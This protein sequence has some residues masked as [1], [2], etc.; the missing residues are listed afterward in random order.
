[1]KKLQMPTNIHNY[2]GTICFFKGSGGVAKILL[3][4]PR[5]ARKSVKKIH[6][7]LHQ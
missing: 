6:L 4:A 7:F 1:M 3:T 2:H 5:K